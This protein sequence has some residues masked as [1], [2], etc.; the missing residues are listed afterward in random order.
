MYFNP[1]DG[2][3]RYYYVKLCSDGKEFDNFRD[4][5]SNKN[6]SQLQTSK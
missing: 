3:H 6:A 4:I 5:S 1:P 2:K